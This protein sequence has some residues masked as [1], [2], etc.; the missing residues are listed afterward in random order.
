MYNFGIPGFLVVLDVVAKVTPKAIWRP[1]MAKNVKIEFA[2]FSVKSRQEKG[3]T[4]S[5]R[6]DS[7]YSTEQESFE[8]SKIAT[9]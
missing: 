8:R 1:R 2:A 4:E 7:S 3:T 5:F 6:N 9:R